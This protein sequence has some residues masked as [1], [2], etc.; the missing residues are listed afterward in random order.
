MQSPEVNEDYPALPK[1][2]HNVPER[3][4]RPLSP[5]LAREIADIPTREPETQ[6]EPPLQGVGERHTDPLQSVVIEKPVERIVEVEKPIVQIVEKIIEKPVEK[7]VPVDRQ[8][9][10]PP[11]HIIEKTYVYMPPERRPESEVQ[12]DRTT[13]PVEIK[14][15]PQPNKKEPLPEVKS[16]VQSPAPVEEK[17]SG[18]EVQKQP[19]SEANKPQ[20]EAT[21]PAQSEHKPE[22]KAS[23]SEKKASGKAIKKLKVY[24]GLGRRHTAAQIDEILDWYLQ[25]GE[26]P[27]YV[28]ER[29]RYAYRHHVKLPERRQLLEQAGLIKTGTGSSIPKAKRSKANVVPIRGRAKTQRKRRASSSV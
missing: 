18:N 20:P 3:V 11:E 25:Y 23:Q 14:P 12:S 6:P 10:P 26:L 9:T 28:S 24:N 2:L 19:N 5:T 4:N 8:P 16:E 13:P 7:I 29:Q 27:D 22:E 21:K 1:P 15:E 17:A